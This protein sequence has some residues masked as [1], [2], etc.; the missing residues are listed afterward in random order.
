MKKLIIGLTVLALVA[1]GAIFIVAQNRHRG[2]RHFG[3]N[4]D[5]IHG[6]MF[7]ELNLN[8]EQKAKVKQ[9]MDASKEKASPLRE[10]MKASRQKLADLTAAGTFDEAPVSAIAGEIGNMQAQMIV[11]RERLRSQ[12][13]AIL[14][15]EQKAKAAEMK[16]KM[17]DRSKARK[18]FGRQ[19]TPE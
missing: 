12:I 5:R 10:S 7:A 11:E 3:M 15:D 6:R 1:A 9:I 19:I 14:T 18:G 2:G 13:F 8:D 16:S 4:G 17:K